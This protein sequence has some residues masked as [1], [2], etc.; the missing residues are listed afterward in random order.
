MSMVEKK[1]EEKLP[2]IPFDPEKESED[3]YQM[4]IEQHGSNEELKR[5]ISE[6]TVESLKSLEQIEDLT[7]K[8]AEQETTINRLEKE[9]AEENIKK[10]RDAVKLLS[11]YAESHEQEIFKAI[12]S[13]FVQAGIEKEFGKFGLT[14]E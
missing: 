8:N 7:K 3:Y 5:E 4:F 12:L 6:A 1:E 11:G 14:L 13:K 9:R 2:V 10:L